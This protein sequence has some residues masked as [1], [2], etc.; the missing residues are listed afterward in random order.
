MEVLRFYLPSGK[1]HTARYIP[2]RQL[3]GTRTSRYRAVPLK[4]TVSGQL[5]KKREEEEEEENKKE[6]KEKKKKEEEEKYLA[7]APSPPAG[8]PR[9]VAALVARG[10]LFSQCGEAEQ[11]IPYQ[12]LQ[13]RSVPPGTGG[14]YRSAKL[15]L[16][17]GIA[18]INR[19]RSIEGDKGKKKKKKK[20]K[21]KRK[22]K[23]KKKR[24][25]R[26]K[27]LASSSPA[28]RRRPRVSHEVSPPSLAGDFSP[29]RGDGMSPHARRK[30]EATKKVIE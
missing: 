17:G 8:R 16:P 13:F 23:K 9:A 29:T 6:E 25:R 12:G 10:R 21:K 30:I 18:K 22:R 11:L 5:R 3:T 15:P 24:E 27:Y 20:K 28:R 14:T 1:A 7:R 4:S 26:K 2:I 19:W